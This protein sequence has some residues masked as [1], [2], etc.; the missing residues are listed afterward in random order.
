ML[1]QKWA[2]CVRTAEQ[3]KLFFGRQLSHKQVVFSFEEKSFFFSSRKE[4]IGGVL[5]FRKEEALL[6]LCF[7]TISGWCVFYC[8]TNKKQRGKHKNSRK[9]R[10]AV[11]NKKEMLTHSLTRPKNPKN[12]KNPKKCFFFFETNRC[13]PNNTC[14]SKKRCFFWNTPSFEEEQEEPFFKHEK[15]LLVEQQSGSWGSSRSQKNNTCVSKKRK[16]LLKQEEPCSKKTN[17]CPVPFNGA[18]QRKEE[19]L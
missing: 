11:L 9:K 8:W 7:V 16:L 1:N 18:V 10:K 17:A 14:L 4:D 2:V 13:S 19:F 6:V 15:P 3:K 12:P 5:C